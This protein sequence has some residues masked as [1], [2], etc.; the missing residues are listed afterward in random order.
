MIAIAK[1]FR[2]KHFTLF[3][4][5]VTALVALATLSSGVLPAAAQTPA[6]VGQWEGPI[7][8]PWVSIHMILLPN[9][10]VL[11]FDGPPEHGGQT[12]TLWNPTDGAF[13]AVP[14]NVTDLFCVGHA[15]LADGRAFIVG[16]NLIPGAGLVDSNI[17]DDVTN[18]WTL[19]SPM[20]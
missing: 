16:G 15:R 18:T 20:K 9:G 11:F 14:N 3:V 1:N 12:A 2:E 6:Q 7:S 17:F 10:K 13:T 19:T 8:W 5:I 4:G